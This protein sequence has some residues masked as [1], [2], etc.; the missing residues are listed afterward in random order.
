MANAYVNDDNGFSAVAAE[1]I[2][3]G[4]AVALR[5]DGLAYNANAATG[6][7]QEYPC[8]GF[9]ETGAAAGGSVEIKDHGAMSYGAGGLAEGDW[10]YLG[11]TDGAITQTAPTTPGDYV[12]VVGFA[13]TAYT[14]RISLHVGAVVGP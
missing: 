12:Q 7:G 6:V 14:W 3:A 8:V 4:A 10:I 11:E 2:A 5:T 9:A 1:T 13:V